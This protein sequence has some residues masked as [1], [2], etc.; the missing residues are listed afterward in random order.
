MASFYSSLRMFLLVKDHKRRTQLPHSNHDK[1]LMYS[2]L[3]YRAL[4]LQQVSHK[5]LQL[6]TISLT[7]SN[8]HLSPTTTVTTTNEDCD[9]YCNVNLRR[10]AF[11]NVSDFLFLHDKSLLKSSVEYTFKK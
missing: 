2:S 3:C 6:I 9:M 5:N 10:A 4:R 8:T 7:L 1:V 11:T